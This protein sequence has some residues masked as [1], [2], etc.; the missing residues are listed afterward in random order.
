MSCIVTQLSTGLIVGALLFLVAAGLT[1]IFGV[2]GI[3]NFAHGSFYMLGA[4]LALTAYRLSDSFFIAILAAVQAMS[5][6]TP[7]SLGSACWMLLA[8]A[9]YLPRLRLT[10]WLRPQPQLIP[11]QASYSS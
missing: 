11:G 7:D 4:Y 8:L 9:R 10:R 3:V 5:R 6:Y 2:L 1:L